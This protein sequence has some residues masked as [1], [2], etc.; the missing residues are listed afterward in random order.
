MVLLLLYLVVVVGSS[1][2]YPSDIYDLYRLQNTIFHL[3][4]KVNRRTMRKKKQNVETE[5]KRMNITTIA[6]S[7][8]NE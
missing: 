3:K 7:K 1:F 4:Y 8:Y 5:N 2:F 6:I